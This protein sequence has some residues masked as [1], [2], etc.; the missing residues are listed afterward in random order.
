MLVVV[1]GGIIGLT[2]AWTL[3]RTGGP[4]T[5]FDS[6]AA[7]GEASW[8][9]AGMLAPGGEFADESRLA[10]MAIA[11]LRQYAK[12]IAALEEASGSPIDYRECG[13]IDVALDEAEENTLRLR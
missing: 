4:V 2:C 3:A 1:G 10:A 9:G 8:A 7:G 5:V 13:A 12:F 6:G 11:S